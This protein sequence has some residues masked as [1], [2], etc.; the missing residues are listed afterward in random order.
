MTLK[1]LLDRHDLGAY[2]GVFERECVVP[3][4]LPTITDEDLKQIFGIKTFGER[5]RFR[6]MASEVAAAPDDKATDARPTS[7]PVER[8][9]VPVAARATKRTAK[10]S[11]VAPT[12]AGGGLPSG[13]TTYK[14]HGPV[15]RY[16]VLVEGFL[17]FGR[18]TERRT[19]EVDVTFDTLVVPPRRFTMGITNRDLMPS[20][21]QACPR[22]EV[23]LTRAFEMGVT[24][25]TQALYEA[26]TG[27][28]PSQAREE[29]DA[30]QRPVEN[31]SWYDAIHFCNALSEKCGL[32]PAYVVGGGTRPKVAWDP[33]ADG[34]RLPT[35]AE[36]ECVA[37]AGTD[38]LWPG[39]DVKGWLGGLAAYEVGWFR[40][41]SGMSTHSVALKRANPWGFYDI[42]GNVWEWTWDVIGAYPDHPR[43]D[44][45]S[46]DKDALDDKGDA[47]PRIRRGGSHAHM[48]ALATTS[49]RGGASP[50]DADS[51]YGFRLCRTVKQ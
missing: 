26:V 2:A 22:H 39:V 36:W 46:T 12:L 47:R 38:E 42:H 11:A 33:D 24:P 30:A 17:G 50:D 9:S 28:N 34:F 48:T 20:T 21:L 49:I 19:A 45:L 25:V 32:R 5:K 6:A 1:E 23:S 37:R 27:T 8:P 40:D 14:V 3:T 43:V 41:N 13:P 31:V 51:T 35:E 29:P 18:K 15:S 44:P 4:D 10:K 7:P 16:A